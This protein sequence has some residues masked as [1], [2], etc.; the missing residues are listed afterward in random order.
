[1]ARDNA[2]AGSLPA[3]DPSTMAAVRDVY[4]ELIRGYVH[5]NW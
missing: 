2:R 3:L 1:Q 5:A 4:E